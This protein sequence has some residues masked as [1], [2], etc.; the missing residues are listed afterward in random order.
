[1]QTKA[2]NKNQIL[3]LAEQASELAKRE[4]RR[5]QQQGKSKD[6]PSQQR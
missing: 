1:M 3:K 4:D 2:A 5:Q 6:K